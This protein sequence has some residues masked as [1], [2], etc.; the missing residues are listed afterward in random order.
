MMGLGQCAGVP[1]E[2]LPRGKSL[3][4]FPLTMVAI[5]SDEDRARGTFCYEEIEEFSK[6][7]KRSI[8]NH[9]ERDRATAT[10]NTRASVF[11]K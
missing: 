3:K 6:Q 1:P 2:E 11:V 8:L 10:R 9:A 5:N 4:E 7:G